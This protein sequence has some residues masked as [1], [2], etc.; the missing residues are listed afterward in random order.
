MSDERGKKEVAHMKTP[1]EKKLSLHLMTLEQART[2]IEIG[3]E[4]AFEVPLVL[5][6]GLGLRAGELLALQWNA[7]NWQD[8]SLRVHQ[9]RHY[10]QG[11]PVQPSFQP[12]KHPRVILLPQGVITCLQEHAARQQRERA[13]AGDRWQPRDLVI[14]TEDGTAL[15]PDRLIPPL[16]DL[17]RQVQFPALRFHELRHTTIHQLLLVGLAPQIVGEILGIGRQVL[18]YGDHWPPVSHTQYENAR[19][20]MNQLFFTT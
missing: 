20:T 11:S 13:S 3:K 17:L 4:H 14:C 16:Q 18:P 5:G 8:G 1:Q 15:S 7:I 9:A 6:L 10:A 19:Q 12:A 2:L